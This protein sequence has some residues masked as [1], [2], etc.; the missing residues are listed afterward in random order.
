[1]RHYGGISPQFLNILAPFLLQNKNIIIGRAIKNG[2]EIASVMFVKHGRS[3]TYQIGVTSLNG[4][5]NNAHHLLLWQGLSVLKDS[6][7]SELDLGGINNESAEGIKQFK[8]G[9]GGKLY[10]L[11]GH[12]S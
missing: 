4:R 1:M 10:R 11:V 3:A 9:M 12:Y 8:K 6:G 5:K 7:I 2:E